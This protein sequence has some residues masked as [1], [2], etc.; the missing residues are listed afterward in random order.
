MARASRAGDPRQEFR[1]AVKRAALQRAAGRCEAVGEDY[2]LPAGERC[3]A[4]LA[5]T[6]WQFHHYPRPAR[7]PHP[8]TAT[9]ANCVVTCPYCNA[10]FNRRVDIPRENKIKRIR[11][12]RGRGPL[13]IER[14]HRDPPKMRSRNSF[15]KARRPMP[16]RPFPRKDKGK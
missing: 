13:D 4:D 2:G 5:L 1:V 11:A 15:P 9:L 10:E 8:D 6:R 16:S 14:P 7:D 3:N 12:A